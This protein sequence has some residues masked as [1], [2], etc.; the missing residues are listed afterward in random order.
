MARHDR[1]Y[2]L[3]FSHP[4]MVRSLLCGF[5]HE[6]WIPLIDFD[7]LEHAGSGS[8][9]SEDLRERA[10]DM[11]WR[12]RWR[13]SDRY[14]Y[15][16]LEF[17]SSPDR[18]MALRILTYVS[19]L[20]Q[21]LAKRQ[22]V[23]DTESLP[24]VVPVVL[25]NGSRP[26]TA[27]ET[28]NI[29][30]QSVPPALRRYLP[31]IRYILIDQRRGRGGRRIVPLNA[32]SALF[33]IENCRTAEEVNGALD[34]LMKCIGSPQH[35]ALRSAFS[36]WLSELILPRLPGGIVDR[37]Q[38]LQRARTMLAAAGPLGRADARCAESRRAV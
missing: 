5:I 2:K 9:V 34:S 13:G 18:R 29:L 35:E 11:I 31:E 15:L 36:T 14:V 19:L 25:Y 1:S 22:N 37:L 17:Q 23:S 26:W 16:L 27:S 4:E 20:Y 33:R 30:I 3:L 6:R 28:L 12:A 7:T 10:H 24:A 38:D 21:D 32:V 8:Q